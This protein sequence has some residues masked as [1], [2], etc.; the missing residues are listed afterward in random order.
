MEFNY[1]G[2]LYPL[3]FY[4]T[5][6]KLYCIFG[7]LLW[8]IH[9]PSSLSERNRSHSFVQTHNSF[10]RVKKNYIYRKP[11]KG[12]PDSMITRVFKSHKKCASVWE[13]A[14]QHQPSHL[15][16]KSFCHFDFLGYH[17]SFAI[18][19]FQLN[20]LF[21]DFASDLGADYSLQALKR[22]FSQI[23]KLVQTVAVKD[24]C[25][26]TSYAFQHNKRKK[27]FTDAV[28]DAEASLANLL[29]SVFVVQ[30]KRELMSRIEEPICV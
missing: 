12:H 4:L 23:I 21:F 28:L 17:F 1:I 26:D 7:R 24:S 30:E 6:A 8:I 18:Q 15:V 25:P 11:H 2:F 3:P 9:M 29:Q 10:L 19:N 22:D 14:T 20:H 16:E 5:C 27:L 13:R